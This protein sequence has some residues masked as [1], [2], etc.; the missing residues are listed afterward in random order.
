MLQWQHYTFDQLEN[1]KNI[2][3]YLPACI[4]NPPKPKQGMHKEIVEVTKRLFQRCTVTI[5][6]I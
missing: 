3:L 6:N 4:L 2:T 5:R 1:H